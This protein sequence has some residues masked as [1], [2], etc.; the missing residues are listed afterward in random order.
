M[1]E[2]EKK[3][4]LT[5]E[6]ISAGTA[7]EAYT[8]GEIDI[9]IATAKR[10]PRS[11]SE[12]QKRVL[13]LAQL[14]KE[15]AEEC[16]YA[17]PRDG[18]VIEGPNVRFA[19]IVASSYQNLRVGTRIIGI[20]ERHVI[21]QGVAFDLENNYAA[22]VEVRR[23]ITDRHGRRYSDDMIVTTANAGSAI[24]MRNAVFKVVPRALTKSIMDDIQKLAM[25]EERSLTE[26]RKA[27]F[28]YW[29]SQKIDKAK[30]L[31]LLG[32]K[33]EADVT[34]ADIDLL[35]K[36]K[37]AIDEETTTIEEAFK[38]E[39]PGAEDVLAPGRHRPEKAGK[40]EKKPESKTTVPEG[41]SGDSSSIPAPQPKPETPPVESPKPPHPNDKLC[42]LNEKAPL[43][44][45]LLLQNQKGL[46]EDAKQSLSVLF[47]IAQQGKVSSHKF[48]EVC[49]A[50]GADENLSLSEQKPAVLA[51]IVTKLM[52]EVKPTKRKNGKLL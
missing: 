29:E 52:L 28:A 12:F 47:G 45:Y 26:S 43:F 24:A 40:E 7:I 27:M 51:E 44:E 25:G 1:A 35:R 31:A 37:V 10:Y 15:T 16:M 20:E 5:P 11:I 30:V 50:A 17:L 18:K 4:V 36:L 8:K 46:S 2:K 48:L 41:G 38:I 21:C 34:L 9:Q 49:F 14:D 32:R 42:Y 22:S 13:N 39:K 19:E 3:E 33:D 23:R 6:T